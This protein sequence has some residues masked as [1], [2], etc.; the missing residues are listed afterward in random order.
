MGA[1]VAGVPS[2]VVTWSEQLDGKLATN[3]SQS[4]HPRSDSVTTEWKGL[5]THSHWPWPQLS[6]SLTTVPVTPPESCQ[7]PRVRQRKAP[8]P[9]FRHIPSCSVR[10]QLGC[11]VDGP[12][13]SLGDSSSPPAQLPVSFHQ[14]NATL[15]GYLGQCP[16]Q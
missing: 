3:W 14:L 16:G 2:S 6:A 13:A 1:W 8:W 9:V 15:S 4:L 5:L 10:A 12:S 7:L 11:H